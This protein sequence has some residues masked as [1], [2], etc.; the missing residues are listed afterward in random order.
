MFRLLALAAALLTACAA[1]PVQEMSDARQAIQAAR[2]AGAADL[3]PQALTEAQ[4]LME[5]A[6]KQLELG[7]YAQARE[8]A[9]SAKQRAAE[10]RQDA[11][12]HREGN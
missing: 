3:S 11:L 4:G 12:K 7:E 2:Q 9:L 5:R 1:A 6:E 10:A 8:S